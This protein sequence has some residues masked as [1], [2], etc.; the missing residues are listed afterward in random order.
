MPEATTKPR[1]HGEHR[2]RHGVRAHGA[3]AHMPA[4]LLRAADG[5]LYQAKQSGRNLIVATVLLAA[6]QGASASS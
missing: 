3:S 6:A 1:P 4:G 2:R 5:A